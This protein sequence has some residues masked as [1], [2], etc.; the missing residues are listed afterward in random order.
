MQARAGAIDELLESGALDDLSTGGDA[1][2]KELAQISSQ[3]AVDAELAALKQ[4][5]G[6]GSAPAGQIGTG[7]GS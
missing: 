5:L 2:D 6:S 1:L 4:Q 3:G 7:G